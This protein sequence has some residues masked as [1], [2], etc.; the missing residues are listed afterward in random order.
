METSKK[1]LHPPFPASSSKQ[2]D[3]SIAAGA[4]G[5]EGLGLVLLNLLLSYAIV[6]LPFSRPNSGSHGRIYTPPN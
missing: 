3:C 6:R 2:P 1:G 5:Q 4:L